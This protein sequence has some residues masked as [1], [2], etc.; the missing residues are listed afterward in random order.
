MKTKNT[1]KK[2]IAGP[3]SAESEEQVLQTA[4]QIAEINKDIY[5]RAGIWKPRTRPGSF[6]G[7]GSVGLKWLQNVKKELGLKVGTEVAQSKHVEHALLMDMDYVWIGARTTV[8]PFQV[9]E[10]A[11]ALQGSKVEVLVKN[12]IHPDIQLWM[13]AFE[14][15]DKCGIKN[16]SGIHRGYFDPEQKTYRNNPGWDFAIKFK[17]LM[18]DT[19]LIFDPSHIAGKRDL[20]S[21]LCQQAVHAGLDGLMIETHC[22]PEKAWS[23]ADQQVTAIQLKQIL[24][25]INKLQSK[26]GIDSETELEHLRKRID[27][28]DEQIVRQLSRRM[29]IAEMIGGLKKDHSLPALQSK[30]WEE[31]M[32]KLKTQ[33]IRLGLEEKFIEKV[34]HNIHEESVRKQVLLKQKSEMN[35]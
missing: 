11:D 13:G 8:N 1:I 17:S 25:K 19:E 15:L 12:P 4:A 9:Q 32:Y 28:V 3:C 21:S 20:V 35:N 29:E 7:I 22:N 24:E 5:F 34:Y 10:I 31:L 27:E 16:V 18:P 23:D 14:R 2:I 30:R 33:A 6:E 26:S